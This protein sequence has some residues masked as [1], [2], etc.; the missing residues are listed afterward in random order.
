VRLRLFPLAPD[1]RLLRGCPAKGFAMRT[2]ASV[3]GPLNQS[4]ELRN[5][6]PPKALALPLILQD[7]GTSHWQ[8]AD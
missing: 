1:F 8:L 4:N 2:Y 5:A 3:K 6:C 7:F